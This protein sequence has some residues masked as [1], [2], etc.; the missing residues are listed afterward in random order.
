M[1]LFLCKIS[2]IF[3]FETS[4]Y[5]MYKFV[6][7]TNDI[8]F[9]TKFMA[10]H[11]LFP[12]KSLCYF[13]IWLQN[14]VYKFRRKTTVILFQ[15]KFL[16]IRGRMHFSPKLKRI[17]I[18]IYISFLIGSETSKYAMYKF[19]RKNYD[20]YFGQNYWLVQATGILVQN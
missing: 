14:I 13:Y 2:L 16:Y 17:Y 4:K 18:Y 6:S 9:Q 10:G 11:V 3:V 8:L 20:F 15:A 5:G 1:S 7:K 19:S 12:L